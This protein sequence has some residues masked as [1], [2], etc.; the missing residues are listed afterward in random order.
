VADIRSA[1]AGS[2]GFCL[3][4]LGQSGFLL[5]F[6]GHYVT[7]DPYLSDSLTTKYA[8]TRTPHVRMTARC[9]DP[10]KLGFVDLALTTHGHTDHFDAETLRAIA[11]APHRSK[12]L[13][14]VLPAAIHAR[15]AALLEGSTARL[16][17]IDAGQ[18]LAPSGIRVTALPAAHPTV[19]RDEALRHLF[20]GYVLHLGRWKVYHSGDTV[21]HD[22]VAACAVA[23]RP[24]IAL[25]PI[26]GRSPDRGVAGN[27]EPAEAAAFARELSVAMVIPHH[28]EMFEF[29]TASP[30]AFSA[31][32]REAR[33]PCTVLRCGERWT[34]PRTSSS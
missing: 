16:L 6:A 20:L 32:C 26:N 13:S 10:K 23:A 19:E 22:Q 30:D 9:V 34:S 12:P 1:E 5:K 8:G 2:D 31:A 11:G 25:L 3:W 28:F 17:P 21:W 29:N 14:I 18:S 33:V 27:L 24:D 4:W 7:I 15:G